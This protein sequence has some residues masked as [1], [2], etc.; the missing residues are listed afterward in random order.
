MQAALP[1]HDNA[2][3]IT[4]SS[5]QTRSGDQNQCLPTVACRPSGPPTGAVAFATSGSSQLGIA[6]RDGSSDAVSSVVPRERE[7]RER[8]GE[9]SP[10]TNG[11]LQAVA[12][13]LL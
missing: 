12:V 10:D 2:S 11:M 7:G 13:T 5:R 6:R 4:P 1:N 8:E 3:A 9:V